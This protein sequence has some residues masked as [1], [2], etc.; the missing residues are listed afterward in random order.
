MKT[1]YSTWSLLLAVAALSFNAHSQIYEFTNA[2][3]SGRFGPTQAQVNAAYSSTNLA[4]NVTINTQGIQEWTVPATSNYRITAVGACGGEGQG[5]YYPGKPGTGATIV[6]DFFLTQ[7]T[8]VKVVVGQKGTYANNGSGGGGGSFVFTGASGGNGLLIAAGGGGGHGHGTASIST[9][10]HGGGG[11]ATQSQVNGAFGTGNGGSNGLGEGG[12]HGTG[13]SFSGSGSGGTGWLSDGDNATCGVSQ[14][15][16]HTSY[17]GG[18]SGNGCNGGF[19]GGAGANGNGTPGGGGG[20]Y[21]GGG[22]G[23]TWNGSA[24]GAGA[25]AGSFNG[26]INQ[27]NTAG[28]TGALSGYTHGSVTFE[29]TCDP[30]NLTVTPNDT[31][32]LGESLTLSASSTNN[33]TISW[34]N[35]ITGGQAFT[36]TTP[37]DTSFTATSTDT[38]DC[39]TVVNVLVDTVPE[40]VDTITACDSY[41]WIDGVTYTSSNST[42]TF[43]VPTN[44]GVGCDTL[45]MLDLTIFV[46]PIVTD[47]V[48]SCGDYTWIDGVTYTSSTNTP[49]VS[50]AGGAA[51]GCDSTSILDLRIGGP[52]SVVDEV[53]AC[54]SYLWINNQIYNNSVSGETFVLQNRYGCDSTVTLELTINK[55]PSVQMLEFNSDYVCIDREPFVLPA[56]QPAGGRYRGPGVSGNMFD[57]AKAG[58]GY[59][60]IVYTYTTSKDCSESDS[61][62]V[63]VTDCLGTDDLSI[64]P[65]LV[66]FPNPTSDLVNITFDQLQSD[67][68]MT[69]MS[70]DGKVVYKNESVTNNQIVIDMVTA[71]NGLYLLKIETAYQSQIFKLVKN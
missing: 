13:C 60:T 17:I 4:N 31:I 3:A 46:S 70:I 52:S 20:G 32:C 43:T 35:G 36:I 28:V 18:S 24:W 64:L 8:V 23:N 30:L 44:D 41:T 57:P 19:G 49:T 27:V 37:G 7:G 42:A 56:A 25:G 71:S 29:A 14:G 26:G 10:A 69:L 34:N 51:S 50:F 2:G 62:T 12:K 11:S 15:G 63:F 48:Y 58:N 38:N 9:G 1:H 54:D 68:R 21:T 6:G 40:R 66:I 5:T 53:E 61:S 39:E 65:G 67:V 55:T 59:H 45:A 16:N 22:G 33:G 47:L